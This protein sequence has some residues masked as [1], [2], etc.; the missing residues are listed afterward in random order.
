L[1]TF[2]ENPTSAK[3]KKKLFGEFVAITYLP[4]LDY[5][6][7]VLIVRPIVCYAMMKLKIVYI[8]FLSVIIAYLICWQRLGLWNNTIQSI[9]LINFVAASVFNVLQQLSLDNISIFAYML[10]LLWQQRNDIVWRIEK[11]TRAVVCDKE[12]L[13]CRDGEMSEKQKRKR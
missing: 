7:E 5:M 2:L 3:G 4:K 13:Y 8:Y 9:N 12:P 6:T 11:A 10:W 1:A